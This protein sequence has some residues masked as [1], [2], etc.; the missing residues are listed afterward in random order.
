MQEN[1][2][3]GVQMITVENSIIVNKLVKDVFAMVTARECFRNAM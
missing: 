1:R 3:K 2:W